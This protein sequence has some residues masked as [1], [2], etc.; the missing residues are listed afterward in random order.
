MEIHASLLESV[1]LNAQW[2]LATDTEYHKIART[3]TPFDRAYEVP[4]GLDSNSK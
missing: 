4:I 1:N 2:S 3:S